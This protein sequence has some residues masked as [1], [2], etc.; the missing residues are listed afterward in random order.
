MACYLGDMEAALTAIDEF[1]GEGEEAATAAE[2]PPAAAVHTVLFTDM[3][4]STTL[5]DRLGDAKAQEVLR[6]YNTIV[7]DAQ[8][9]GRALIAQLV[10]A[11]RVRRGRGTGAGP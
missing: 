9:I 11:D 3:E 6:T 5:T 4:G 10:P 2:A 1:L 7:R 8:R